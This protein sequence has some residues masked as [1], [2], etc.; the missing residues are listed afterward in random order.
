MQDALLSALIEIFAWQNFLAMVVGVI[1]GIVVG[2][3]PGLTA[4]MGIAILIPLTFTMEPLIALGMV[5]GIYNGGIYGG[6]IPAILLGIPGTSSSI[7]TTFDG[8][9][10][11][12][13]GD[14]ENALRV[15]AYSSAIGGIAS[16]VALLILAPPLATVTLLFGPAEY[17]WVAVFGMCSIAVLL[18]DDAFKGLI[19]AAIGLLIGTIGIDSVSGHERFTFDIFYLT[20]GFDFIVL[21]AGLYGIP[22]AIT[23]AQ[24]AASSAIASSGLSVTRAK[25]RFRDWKSLVPTW[26]RSSTIGIVVGVLPG[27]GGTMAAFLSYNEARRADP[28]P[29]SFGKGSYKGLAASECGNNADNAS[30]L[31]PTL[32]LG[33]PGNAVAAVI[34]GAFLVQGLQPGPAMF[35]SEPVLVYAFILQMIM[36]AGMLFFLGGMIALRVFA[37]VLRLPPALIAPVVICLSVIGV[38]T[39]QNSIFDIY[40]LL[41]FGVLGYLL[42]ATGFPLAPVVLGL[43]LGPMAEQQLRLALIIA[44]GDFVAISTS[45]V[46]LIIISLILV[47]LAIP[48]VRFVRGHIVRNRSRTR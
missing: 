48:L 47:V 42:Q 33:V 20:G 40:A 30:S 23:L 31:I 21:L 9:P 43:I 22:P 32:T 19:S 35:R 5:A 10:L 37:P 12:R 15:S 2:A 7:P 24:T 14:A 41:G 45:A 38:Y 8:V 17:F 4:T 44:R 26:I 11:A 1:G 6:A 27:V 25:T 13:R 34:M 16:G 29:S 36:T 3:L 28:D 18:G 39:I 46:S